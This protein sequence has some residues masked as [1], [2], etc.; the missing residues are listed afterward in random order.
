M[1]I[2]AKPRCFGIRWENII[3]LDSTFCKMSRDKF[4]WW[5]RTCGLCSQ[6][7]RVTPIIGEQDWVLKLETM[8]T[9]R[10]YLWEGYDILMYEASSHIGSLVL[11]RSREERRRIQGR[12]SKKNYDPSES[13]GEIH[14]K[15][16][17]FLTPENFKFGMWFKFRT[18][19]NR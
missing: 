2:G 7:R 17:R 10:Y 8:Y 19:L 5:E 13:W 12:I 3:F 9:S 15:G 1:V 16:G 18:F 14:F 4:K 6:D 11:S